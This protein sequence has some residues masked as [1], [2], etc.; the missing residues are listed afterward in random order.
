MS[1][2]I[3][4]IILSTLLLIMGSLQLQA[5]TPSRADQVKAVFIYN[6]TQ[7]VD[8]PSN[9]FSN[10]SAPFIIGILGKDPFGSYMDSVVAGERFGSH[11]IEVHRFNS[12]REARNCQLLFINTTEPDDAIKE[13]QNRSILT[14]SDRKDFAAYGGMVR[15]FVE[16]NKMKL[17]INLKAAKAAN[18]SISSKLLRL[19]DVI[20]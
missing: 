9:S 6:F 3:H 16:N 15:L 14:V 13:L 4:H 8:W 19:A 17:Q 2:R 1:K 18:L 12:I 7:F 20:Q 10:N 11:P 5:Q